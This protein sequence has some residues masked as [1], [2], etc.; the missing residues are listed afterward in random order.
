MK[1]RAVI[2]DEPRGIVGVLGTYIKTKNPIA[3]NLPSGV[4]DYFEGV[5]AGDEGEYE[6]VYNIKANK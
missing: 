4:R 6:E 5:K 2:P 1:D 3:F